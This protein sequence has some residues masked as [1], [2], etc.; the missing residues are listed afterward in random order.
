MPVYEYGCDACGTRFEI[1]QSMHDAPVTACPDCKG[2][3]RRIYSGG[4]GFLIKG[5]DSGTGIRTQCGKAQTCCGSRTP[6]ET[7]SCGQE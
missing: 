4:S 6:C 5:A 1:S 3:V 2:S 7:P